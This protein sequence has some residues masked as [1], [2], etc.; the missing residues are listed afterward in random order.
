MPHRPPQPTAAPPPGSAG[1]TESE[2]A[3]YAFTKPVPNDAAAKRFRVRPDVLRGNLPA[4][5]AAAAQDT[6]DIFI[7]GP[8]AQLTARAG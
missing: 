3:M 4:E 7:D 5:L 6:H 8:R 1:F 2:R